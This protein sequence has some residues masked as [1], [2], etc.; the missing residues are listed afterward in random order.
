ME[1]Q[2]NVQTW[3]TLLRMSEKYS[4]QDVREKATSFVLENFIKVSQ[5]EEFLKLPKDVVCFFLGNDL[6]KTDGEEIHVFRAAKS[7][8]ECEDSRIGFIFNVMK[9]VRF[10]IISKALLTDEVL[11][12]HK[13]YKEKNCAG[14]V[15]EAL[16]FHAEVYAQPLMTGKQYVCRGSPGIA[17]LPAGT[18][19][20]GFCVENTVTDVHLISA[21]SASMG[22]PCT[23]PF[24]YQSLISVSK[25]NFVFVIG[26]DSTHFGS[27]TMRYDVNRDD[28]VLLA[29]PNISGLI[30]ATAICCGAEIYLIGGIMVDKTVAFTLNKDL[31]L[32][33]YSYSI[34]DN[35]WCCV[36]CTFP[37]EAKPEHFFGAFA[38]SAT[39]HEGTVYLAGGYNPEFGS[40]SKLR[41]Y[42]VAKHTWVQETR[43]Q[44]KRSN[45]LL[46]ACPK[47]HRLFAVG[48]LVRDKQG[49]VQRPV[50]LIEVY[51]SKAKQWTLL[52][53]VI[54]ISGATSHFHNGI[55]YVVGGFRSWKKEDAAS[56]AIVRID[57]GQ[58]KVG[59]KKDFFPSNCP[60]PC[61]YHASALVTLPRK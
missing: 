32:D 27:V 18:R 39:L 60:A 10:P 37:P 46:E 35:Q 26:T 44:Y 31:N 45:L 54:S 28:W 16:C 14:L 21:K 11:G 43:M 41:V 24:A 12:W 61:V 42:N 3:S 4:L 51:N 9:C 19:S 5:M 8:I 2:I 59:L 7:W 33:I 49:V 58:D 25:G 55:L 29:T 20:E 57:T 30:G 23:L 1:D 34:R 36:P 52:K 40:T 56:D 53:T 47:T 6:L 38:A 15:T 13:I 48:G 22:K 17:V 50:S